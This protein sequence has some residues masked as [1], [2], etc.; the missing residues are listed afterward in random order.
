MPSSIRLWQW[1]NI[2][3]IDTALVAILWQ[4]SM[5]KALNTEIGWVASAVLGLSVWLTYVADRLFDVRSLENTVLFSLRHQFAKRYHQRLW[6]LWFMI[7]AIDLLLATQLTGSQLKNGFILLLFCLLYTASNQKLSKHFFPKEICVALIYAGGIIIFMPVTSPLG[8]F[9]LFAL[10]CLLNCLIIGAGEKT[11]DAKMRLY[12]LASLVEARWLTP[13][14]LFGVGLAVWGGSELWFSLALSYGLLGLLHG[15][16][17]RI[18]IEAFRV[19]AD[20]TLILGA[21]CALCFIE[22]IG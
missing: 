4:L 6:Y 10:L 13:L 12:S 2:L 19:L 3:A 7:L 1:P 18:N 9:G 21:L 16:R 11:I 15:L 14:A 20:A 22:K 17:N 5:A 8:F